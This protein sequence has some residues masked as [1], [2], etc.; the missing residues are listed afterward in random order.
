MQSI[1]QGWLLFELTSSPFYLGLF[2]FLKN[3]APIVPF[4]LGG[5]MSDRW[6]RAKSCCGSA[7]AVNGVGTSVA[8]VVKTIE[9][10]HIFVLGAI[11]STT[12]AFEQP[13]RQALIPQL[14]QREDLVNA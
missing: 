5:L 1:A 3:G 12:W 7:I 9:V 6:E 13:V 8:R 2:Q 10:W 14:V 11:T 4:R